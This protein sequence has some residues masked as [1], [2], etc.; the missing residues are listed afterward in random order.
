VSVGTDSEPVETCAHDWRVLRQ[1]NYKGMFHN[2][3]YCTRCLAMT[4]RVTPTEADLQAPFMERV[5]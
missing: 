4:D 3:F 5:R 1:W 2:E